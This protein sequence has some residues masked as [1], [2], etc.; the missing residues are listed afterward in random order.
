MHHQTANSGSGFAH[1][2]DNFWKIMADCTNRHNVTMLTG[3]FNM[4]LWAVVPSLVRAD[5]HID[6]VASFGWK[7]ISGGGAI[8]E[9]VKCDSCGIF[10]TT[11]V[12]TFI[13]R[14]RCRS[15]RVE[16]G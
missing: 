6:V 12:G 13:A 16:Q 1:T 7:G 15:L 3:D 5:V 14:L 8:T 9:Q 2:N 11:G 4:S 10:V